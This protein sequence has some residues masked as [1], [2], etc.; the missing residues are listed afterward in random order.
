MCHAKSTF[1]QLLTVYLRENKNRRVQCQR[2]ESD[3][4]K[5][6][7]WRST[8]L[9]INQ[10]P[11]QW[12]S[13]DAVAAGRFA[14]RLAHGHTGLAGA[15]PACELIAL[16]EQALACQGSGGACDS[17]GHVSDGW[18]VKH[19]CCR[20]NG[21]WW[22]NALSC[23]AWQWRCSYNSGDWYILKDRNLDVL[24]NCAH[25]EDCGGEWV[26]CPRIPRTDK[27]HIADSTRI[28]IVTQDGSSCSRLT[29]GP[30]PD[31]NTYF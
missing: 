20:V 30:L 4:T 2:H 12:V 23:G 25:G 22:G 10:T 6:P 26:H 18:E 5:I 24:K 19:H 15:H 3:I 31:S 14:G 17:G 1:Q 27:K 11:Q 13:P 8:Q 21:K 16:L 29:L 28:W 9:R 7:P